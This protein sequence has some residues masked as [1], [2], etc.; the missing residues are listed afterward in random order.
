MKN[1]ST[2]FLVF[3][4]LTFFNCTQDS[5]PP[6]P[7]SGGGGTPNT[8]GGTATCSDGIQNGDETGVDCGGSSCTPCNTSVCYPVLNCDFTPI[9]NPD[10]SMFSDTVTYTE[11]F[12]TI[13]TS[14]YIIHNGQYYDI[15]NGYAASHICIGE[16]SLY[17]HLSGWGATIG[18]IYIDG[19]YDFLK[20]S[21]E[22]ISKSLLENMNLGQY[23][24]NSSNCFQPIMFNVGIY[25]ENNINYASISSTQR[26]MTIK[27]IEITDVSTQIQTKFRYL[28]R[29]SL[30]MTGLANENDTTDKRNISYDIQILVEDD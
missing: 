24:I 16:P 27:Q 9:S 20:E 6:T 30:D 21:G 13:T 11:N 10:L 26:Y 22:R 8:G 18:N 3:T 4:L 15:G 12:S 14:N 25:Q 1:I 2:L 23:K 29:G 7:N 28:I 5:N 17:T 19:F